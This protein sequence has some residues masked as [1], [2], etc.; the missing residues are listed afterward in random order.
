[1]SEFIYNLARGRM[2]TP[3]FLPSVVRHIWQRQIAE[4]KGKAQFKRSESSLRVIV[5]SSVV[6]PYPEFNTEWAKCIMCIPLLIKQVIE[7]IDQKKG[8]KMNDFA[9]FFLIPSILE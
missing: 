2:A 6:N 4:K 9:P 7:Y 5:L 8:G 3:C 1:M